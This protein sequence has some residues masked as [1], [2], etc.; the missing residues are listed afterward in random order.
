[1]R[2]HWFTDVQ[3]VFIQLHVHVHVHVQNVSHSCTY[4]Y[5][6]YDVK[7]INYINK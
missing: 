2:V 1:M 6:I 3:N 4:M 5:N 7:H